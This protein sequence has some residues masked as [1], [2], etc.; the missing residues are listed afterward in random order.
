MAVHQIPD[1]GYY[2]RF[3]QNTPVEA[4]ALFRDGTQLLDA[5]RIAEACPKLAESLHAD[6][7]LGTLL[8]LATCHERQ[9]RTASAWGE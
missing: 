7:A 3:L 6:P 8:Y 4:E 2:V 1:L 9:G 5:G